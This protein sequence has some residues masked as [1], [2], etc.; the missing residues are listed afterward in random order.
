MNK[1][2]TLSFIAIFC[3]S[4]IIISNFRPSP[5]LCLSLDHSSC[6]KAILLSKEKSD[7]CNEYHWKPRSSN[8]DNDSLPI[9]D[10]IIFSKEFDTLEIRLYE[11]YD[12]VTLFFIAESAQTLT[13]QEKP[14]YL[15][16]NWSKFGKYH[17][18][19]RRI[20]VELVRNVTNAWDNE[21]R[22]RDEG[23]RLALANVT[24]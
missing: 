19:I 16:E 24:E 23:L 5:D 12:Y 7:L 13:G 10:F 3:S 1:F 14:M 8:T 11:L 2:P 4:V 6:K 18:K 15:K 17:Q 20:E 22:M 9:Y 21:K